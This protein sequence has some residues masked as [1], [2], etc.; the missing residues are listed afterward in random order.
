[1]KY[2]NVVKHVVKKSRWGSYFFRP[3]PK[4]LLYTPVYSNIV[5]LCTQKDAGK[6]E[7]VDTVL[8]DRMKHVL[9]EA[10]LH[11]PWY[12]DNV[13]IDP[14]SIT[15]ENVY[16]KLSEFPYLTKKI[17]MN[18][19][20]S[21]I[22]EKYS[23][24]Q[25][26]TGS[27]EGTT[28]EGLLIASSRREI[29][30]QQAFH[31]YWMKDI[32]FDFLKTRILRFA[33]EGSV[34]I[35]M[36]PI[37][38]YGNRLLVSPTHLVKDWFKPIYDE[39][40]NFSPEVIHAYPSLLYLF[41]RYIN[42]NNLP[43]VKVQGLLLTSDVFL[44]YHYINFKQAFGNPRIY[45]SYNMSEHVALGKAV[46]NEAD[47][48]IG[49]QLDNL[50][51]YNENLRDKYG[52]SEIVGTSYWNEAMPFIRYRTQDF[53]KINDTGF[54]KSLD[55]RGQ[56]FLTTKKRDKIAGTAVF[57]VESYVWNYVEAMQFVQHQRGKLIILIIPRPNYTNE[58]GEKIILNIEQKWPGLFDYEIRLVEE[59]IKGRSTKVNSVIVDINE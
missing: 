46:V 59:M 11:V 57:D 9:E 1:M 32:H 8:R 13:G 38:R 22:N 55:G 41:A 49:Y 36:S 51:A 44:Y 21:F 14:Q 27:T 23:I 58:I 53:G 10:L 6:S 43:P 54:I 4:S 18:N 40:V 15:L 56:T 35:S 47:K 45:G 7:Y 5:H 42:E 34:D 26:K 20:N 30:V 52:N 16:E 2:L 12:R 50:Y 24:R 29:G 31:E 39:C 37:Q 17:V 28:G 19:W 25:L 33:C 48:T 3:F